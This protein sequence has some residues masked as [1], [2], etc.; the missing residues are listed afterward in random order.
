M[1]QARVTRMSDDTFQTLGSMTCIK[2]DGQLFVCKTLELPWR[3][4]ESNVSCIPKGVYTCKYTR[5]AHFSQMKGHDVYTYE[6]TNVPGR[7][8]VRIHSANLS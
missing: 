1:K 6:I 7:A 4:N 3:N 2:D 5:S 8:G